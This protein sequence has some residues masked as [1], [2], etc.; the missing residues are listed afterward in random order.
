M[1]TI[2]VG[3][4]GTDRGED[5]AV[6]A[7]RLGDA[8]D[9]GL[10]LALAYRPCDALGRAPKSTES[11][12]SDSLAI[13][14]DARDR[15]APGAAI[16]AMPAASPASA[17]QSLARRRR[18]ALIVVGSASHGR[19]GRVVPGTTGERLLH[20]ASCPVVVVPRGFARLSRTALARI[21][22]AIDRGNESSA[23]LAAASTLAEALA[24]ELDVIRAYA[25]GGLPVD[26]A[27]ARG[28][29]ARARGDLTAA[30]AALPPDVVAHPIL[31]RD[32][33][34]RALAESS[35]RLDL[36]VI[37][38]RGYGPAHSL[39]LGG[40]SGRLIRRAACPVLVVPPGTGS[41]LSIDIAAALA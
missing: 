17:L 15:L 41:T 32:A 16:A 28:L 38:S 22:V 36:L 11:P 10:L 40:V 29:E 3:V 21:G 1:T 19:A 8:M 34:V 26:A 18:A 6:F 24:A 9:I 20:G 14:A 35:Q 27:L 30:L 39:L 31:V 12:R 25:P 13:L 4:D 5:A 33:P 2:V 23:P 37:G 7:H